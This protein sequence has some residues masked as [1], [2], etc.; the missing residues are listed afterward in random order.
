MPVHKAG[1]R[2]Y[3]S[4]PFKHLAKGVGVGG[5]GRSSN[6]ALNLT[7]FVDM[8]TI[9]VTFLL[10]V[11]STSGELLKAQKGLELPKADRKDTLQIAP[12]IT[13]TKPDLSFQGNQVASLEVTP[14]KPVLLRTHAVIGWTTHAAVQ[15][16]AL[17]V[18]TLG[19]HASPVAAHDVG[20]LPGGSQVSPASS[21]PLL[22]VALTFGVNAIV[23]VNP[24]LLAAVCVEAVAPLTRVYVP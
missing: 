19:R 15:P 5:G 23:A 20:Q 3:R 7:P 16:A 9:L 21:L 14:S 4:V 2:L 22:Q 1:P 24:P 12:I 6:I 13:V 8:M 10:M 18:S 11:F 17:P